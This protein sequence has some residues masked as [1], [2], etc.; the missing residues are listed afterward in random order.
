MLKTSEPPKIMINILNSGKTKA[1]TM[2]EKIAKYKTSCEE[3]EYIY[4]INILYY[5]ISPQFISIE[6]ICVKNVLEFLF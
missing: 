3:L 6:I 2:E 1:T 5:F 4:M